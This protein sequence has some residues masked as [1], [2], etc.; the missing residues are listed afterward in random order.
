MLGFSLSFTFLLKRWG[1]AACA[2]PWR[3]VE[4]LTWVTFGEFAPLLEEV[5]AALGEPERDTRG[6]R[7]NVLVRIVL[8]AYM[9]ITVIMLI[10]LLIAMMS[11][12]FATVKENARTE[13][14]FARMRLI[15]DYMDMPALP[16]P[17]NLVAAPFR[18]V[19]AV[20]EAVG[21]TL[22]GRC[23][24][25]R[26]DALAALGRVGNGSDAASAQRRRTLLRSWEQGA[27]GLVSALEAQVNEVRRR[28]R[29][30]VVARFFAQLEESATLV[31]DR[32]K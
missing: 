12:T 23:C 25:H 20:L 24:R 13:W 16:A 29:K 19:G 10:N 4:E 22:S 15:E 21:A 6:G 14:M 17:L 11:S 8:V 5:D 28:T 30:R 9:V 3:C 27:G 2:T 32:Q 7:T 18:V 31:P 1:V 26:P